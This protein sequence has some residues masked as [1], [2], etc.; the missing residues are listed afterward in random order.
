MLE[1]LTQ[2]TLIAS[3]HTVLLA[4]FIPLVLVKKRDSTVAVAWCLVVLLM[5]IVGSLLFW[6]FGSNYVQRRI[7][8]KRL[9][10]SEF[11]VDHPPARRE[12]TRGKAG[13]MESPHELAKIAYELDAFPVSIGNRVTLFHETTLAYEGILSAIEAARHHVHLEFFIIRGDATGRC[14]I[15]L[16]TAK[17]R[18]GVQVRLLY[19]AVGSLFFP[20][21]LLQP[22]RQAGGQVEAFL[23]VNPF[24][25]WI[26]VNLRNH[27]KI[28]IVDG[29]SAFTG[30]M[31]IGDEYLGKNK[32]FGYWRDTMLRVD[33]PAV[34][35]FQRIFSE[36]WDYAS[37]Q[38]FTEP[39]YFPE[40]SIQG[41][42]TV[43]VMESG[44]DQTMN[45]LREIYFAAIVAA[46]KR[47]WIASPYFV[48]DNGLL[49]A[50]RLA[51]LRGVDVRLLCLLRPDH[52]VSFYASRYYW[53]DLLSFR[54][55]VY[56][57]HKGMMHSKIVIVDED[58]AVVGSAN[59]DNRSLHLNF[60]AGIAL[61]NHEQVVELARHYLKDLEDSI[62]LDNW[63]FAQRPF[64]ARLLENGCRL[65]A[66]IL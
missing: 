60:E 47:L 34:A 7:R 52:L 31:N 12:A 57:Y 58:W 62:P 42:H 65:F 46:K 63:T 37:G 49:D 14:L 29:Q 30:G 11:D 24:R 59:L 9:H 22:L 15:D 32:T 54:G 41:D 23:P 38:S 6:A 27:R 21:R 18:A 4:V 13:T 66:P 44:P 48:P 1:T 45:S 17:A 20:L 56:Q 3:I 53:A 26:R 19:D 55:R 28:V 50:L 43:Q 64:L 39:D 2:V 16:L 5:P 35:A 8:K 33:G 10:R 25:S 36:D 51:C 61:Y 40:I